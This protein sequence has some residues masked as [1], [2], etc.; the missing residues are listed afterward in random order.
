[1][2][3]Y[4]SALSRQV[5]EAVRIHMRGSVLNSRSEYNRCQITRL[6]IPQPEEEEG[7]RQ[8]DGYLRGRSEMAHEDGRLLDRFENQTAEKRKPCNTD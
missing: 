3:Y 7:G 6:T 5:G 1:M 2:A 8:E 4:S